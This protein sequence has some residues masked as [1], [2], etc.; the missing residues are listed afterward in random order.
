MAMVTHVTLA[1]GIPASTF[2]EATVLGHATVAASLSA[3]RA[4]K[5]IISYLKSLASLVALNMVKRIKHI[6]HLS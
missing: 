2:M 3:N 4:I 5:S 1:T 6:V